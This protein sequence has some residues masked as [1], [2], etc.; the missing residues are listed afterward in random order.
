MLNHFRDG[1]VASERLSVRNEQ[2]IINALA[3][4]EPKRADRTSA[5]LLKTHCDGCTRA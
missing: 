3:N 5:A 2:A 4:G 1:M